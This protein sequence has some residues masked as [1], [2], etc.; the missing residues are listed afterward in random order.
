MAVPRADLLRDVWEVSP[1][2]Q[3]RTIDVFMGRLRKLIEEDPRR[4]QILRSVRG[5]GYRLG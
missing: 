2:S 1:E 3:T 5:I 4:P